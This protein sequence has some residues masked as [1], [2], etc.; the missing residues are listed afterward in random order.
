MVV[1]IAVLRMP[2]VL[3]S[4][5][6]SAASSFSSQAFCSAGLQANWSQKY[7]FSRVR[8]PWRAPYFRQHRALSGIFRHCQT[9]SDIFQWNQSPTYRSLSGPF[10]RG[11]FP[12]WRGALMGRFPSLMGSFLTFMG[13]FSECLHGPFPS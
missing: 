9:Y 7:A 8:L 3:L 5:F 12:P 6:F 4:G 10:S 2:P 1:V 13:R 11:C